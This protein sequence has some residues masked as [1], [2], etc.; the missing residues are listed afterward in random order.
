[1]EL[2]EQPYNH[3][4]S[5]GSELSISLEQG[6]RHADMSAD[7]I[8]AS[9]PTLERPGTSRLHKYNPEEFKCI[10]IDEAHHAVSDSYV[11]IFEYFKAHVPNSPIPLIGFT[12]T[13]RRHDRKALK[14]VFDIT[15]YHKSFQEMIDEK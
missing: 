11:R 13:A 10:I 15:S 5:N 2:L 1:M 14:A 8:V 6:N 12:A 4:I 9:V 3:I 7:V